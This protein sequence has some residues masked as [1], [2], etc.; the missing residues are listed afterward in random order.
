[1]RLRTTRVPGT[2][3]LS[4]IAASVAAAAMLVEK[5]TEIGV[6][7]GTL[8]APSAG[9][10]LRITG[11]CPVVIVHWWSTEFTTPLG[12][13]MPP[14]SVNRYEV[15]GARIARGCRSV[16]SVSPSSQTILQGASGPALN[17]V[18]RSQ[19]G[20]GWFTEKRPTTEPVSHRAVELDGDRSVCRDA[21]RA[22]IR[23]E[24]DDLRGAGKAPGQRGE[25]SP[26][27]AQSAVLRMPAARRPRASRR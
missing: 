12:S 14:A 5:L 27:T 6:S 4:W 26:D 19:C 16:N 11:A 18:A 22:A 7:T 20:I 25:I 23:G 9:A 3:G 15:F 17:A 10:M 8:V 1:M 13:L 24:L 2:G 21:D